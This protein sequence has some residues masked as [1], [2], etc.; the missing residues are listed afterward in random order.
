MVTVTNND[1]DNNISRPVAKGVF[2][3]VPIMSNSVERFTKENLSFR[4]LPFRDV[5]FSTFVCE[6]MRLQTFQFQNISQGEH[7]YDFQANLPPARPAVRCWDLHALH[8]DTD[9]TALV[10]A[11]TTLSASLQV[12]LYNTTLSLTAM[13]LLH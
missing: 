1:N 7:L 11:S 10:I 5:S 8:Y 12:V 2:G 4:V 3:D 9:N 6:K 13:S